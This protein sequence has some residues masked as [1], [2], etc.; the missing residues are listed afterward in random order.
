M[1]IGSFLKAYFHSSIITSTDNVCRIVNSH[2]YKAFGHQIKTNDGYLLTAHEICPNEKVDFRGTAF[3]M[4]GLFR[5]SADFLAT[6][7]KVALPYLLSDNGF[8]V[9]MGNSRG[10]KFGTQHEKY[11]LKSREFWNFS[12]HEIGLYDL[13]AMIQYTLKHSAS[14]KVFYV[15]HSQGCSSLLALLASRP[16]YNSCFSQVHLMAPAVFLKHGTSLVYKFA[17]Y[18]FLV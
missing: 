9:F 4:H 1:R 15:G 10:S 3:L 18:G 17:N 5:N 7:P 8:H 12:W 6:G 13:S 2:G 11:S 16:E 14:N